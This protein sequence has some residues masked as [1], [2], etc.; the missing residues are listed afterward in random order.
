M[1][2][3]NCWWARPW[4]DLQSLG[5][6][7]VYRFT[8][9]L[10]RALLVSQPR[11]PPTG[12]AGILICTANTQGYGNAFVVLVADLCRPGRSLCG[13]RRHE[14]IWALCRLSD[15]QTATL[16]PGLLAKFKLYALM[17]QRLQPNPQQW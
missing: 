15:N 16:L 13:Y 11:N 1:P 17:S 5:T 14:S 8:D 12:A 3:A 4:A 2:P 9:S 6:G 7:M 10:S